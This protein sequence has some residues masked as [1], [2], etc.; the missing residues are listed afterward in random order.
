MN[1]R[2]QLPLGQPCNA[3]SRYVAAENGAS[4]AATFGAFRR[5]HRYPAI[6][7]QCRRSIISSAPVMKKALFPQPF[8]NFRPD[9]SQSAMS[10]SIA[11]SGIT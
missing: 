2:S 9:N 6:L 7:L 11:L 5:Y 10:R 3:A 8:A 1:G 4:N